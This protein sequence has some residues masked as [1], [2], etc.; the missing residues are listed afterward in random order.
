MPICDIEYDFLEP[1]FR[2]S[3]TQLPAGYFCLAFCLGANRDWE[4]DYDD[5]VLELLDEDECCYIIYRL[6]ETRGRHFEHVLITWQ[7]EE[8]PVS[9]VHVFTT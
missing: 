6:D 9:C 3:K 4:D 7:P 1:S 8:A 2:V 5:M